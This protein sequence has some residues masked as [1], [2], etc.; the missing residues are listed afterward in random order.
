VRGHLAPTKLGRHTLNLTGMQDTQLPSSLQQAYH[1]AEYRVHDQSGLDWRLQVDRLQPLLLT[2]YSAHQ[3]DCASF[4]TACNPRG[5]LLSDADNARRM[6]QL[7][8]TLRV[9]AWIFSEGQGLDPQ[10]LWP[11]EASVLIWGMD[12]PTARAWGEQWE[13]NA[14]LWCG[15]DA[16][17]QLLW[18]R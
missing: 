9:G 3:V 15:A 8:Q 16:I 10:G 11:G 13:Q 4:L 1:R 2:H 18:L 7:R 17:P 12:A 14:V 5:Q 6:Q